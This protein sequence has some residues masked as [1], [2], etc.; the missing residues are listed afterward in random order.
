M[1]L[2][3]LL[4]ICPWDSATALCYGVKRNGFKQRLALLRE[5]AYV[6][7]SPFSEVILFVCVRMCVLIC[8]YAIVY[9]YNIDATLCNPKKY[10]R[11]TLYDMSRWQNKTSNSKSNSPPFSFHR[12]TFLFSSVR[13][14]SCDLSLQ[15]FSVVCLVYL[16][17]CSI[18]FVSMLQEHS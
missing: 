1:L 3:F 15:I 7:I 18:R 16:R 17:I 11:Q 14:H 10:S 12:N 8:M 2:P 4:F 5:I 9:M 6:L 13:L